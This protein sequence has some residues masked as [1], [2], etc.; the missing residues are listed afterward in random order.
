[1]SSLKLEITSKAYED[2]DIISEYIKTDNPK[3]A[4]NIAKLFQKTFKMLAKHPNI[5]RKRSDFTYKETR[6]YILKKKYLVLY[7]VIDDKIVRILR[8][9]TTYQDI[10]SML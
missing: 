1:M 7:R 5:G 10:C 3:A 4:H 9:L 2:V 6:F 8:V